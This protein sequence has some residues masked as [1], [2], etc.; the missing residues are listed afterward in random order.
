[1]KNLICWPHMAIEGVLTRRKCAEK[2]C[3]TF[4]EPCLPNLVALNCQILIVYD[5]GNFEY[6]HDQKTSKKHEKNEKSTFSQKLFFSL[7]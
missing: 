7:F 5:L 1:M 3:A 4:E 2:W 6:L